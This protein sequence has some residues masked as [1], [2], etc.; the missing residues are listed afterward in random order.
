MKNKIIYILFYFMLGGLGEGGFLIMSIFL[1]F[2]MS[3]LCAKSVALMLWKQKLQILV[4]QSS[5]EYC[6][7]SLHLFHILHLFETNFLLGQCF[8]V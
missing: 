3:K 1:L 4:I 5:L 6:G 2:L 8:N 7:Q